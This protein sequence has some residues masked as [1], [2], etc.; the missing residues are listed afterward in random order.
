MLEPCFWAMRIIKP[1]PAPPGCPLRVYEDAMHPTADYTCKHSTARR[2]A[3][4]G[5]AC[6]YQKP[7]FLQ[8]V[9]QARTTRAMTAK[10]HA[11]VWDLTC[12]GANICP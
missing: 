9:E 6:S 8:G 3:V 7:P 1:T 4:A 5:M 10:K 11:A 12:Q 2:T